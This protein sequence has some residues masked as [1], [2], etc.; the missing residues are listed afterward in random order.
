MEIEV[1]LLVPDSLGRKCE[2][3]ASSRPWGGGSRVR[4]PLGPLMGGKLKRQSASLIRKRW[5]VRLQPRPSVP[6]PLRFPLGCAAFGRAP[7]RLGESR[8]P[9]RAATA[10][11]S[12]VRSLRGA[13]VARQTGSRASSSDGMSACLTNK[14]P[15]VRLQP[16]PSFP[17]PL[18]FPLGCAAF[19]RASQ[20]AWASRA[21][22]VGRGVQCGRSSAGRAPA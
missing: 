13:L 22:H 4:I 18:R 8:P 9:C 11:R 12:Q 10:Q 5:L 7:Q 17:R 3:S 20:R 15:L 6:R 1:R 21:R 2:S 14:R 19:G 16:R